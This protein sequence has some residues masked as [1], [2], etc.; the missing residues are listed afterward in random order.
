MTFSRFS[1]S[2]GPRLSRRPIFS[3]FFSSFVRRSAHATGFTNYVSRGGARPA[4]ARFRHHLAL[5]RLVSDTDRPER[6]DAASV[7]R[8]QVP[9]ECGRA[10]VYIPSRVSAHRERNRRPTP[11]VSPGLARSRAKLLAH[12]SVLPEL[13]R[14][15][16]STGTA[17]PCKSRVSSHP[18]L[19]DSCGSPHA[20]YP[21]NAPSG[22]R[23]PPPGSHG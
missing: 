14:S 8:G 12:P 11:L 2:R 18:P 19:K 1:S 10:P 17:P 7:V 23:T 9:R 20:G 15:R 4:L 21:R 22:M 3:S 5:T 16:D 13:A 6:G